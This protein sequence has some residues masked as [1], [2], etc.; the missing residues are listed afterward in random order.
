MKLLTVYIIREVIK[1]KLLQLTLQGF[2]KHQ[3]QFTVYLV[4]Q[5]LEW[6]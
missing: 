4:Y 3:T 6:G 5:P 2:Y 1:W